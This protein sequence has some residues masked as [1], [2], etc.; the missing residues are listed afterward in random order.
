MDPVH[1]PHALKNAA[2]FRL[3]CDAMELL[4]TH[5][6]LD[7]FVVAS[8]DGAFGVLLAKLAA[9]GKRIVR[10]AVDSSLARRRFTTGEERV[11]YD[12]WCTW[13]RTS[14]PELGQALDELVSAVDEAFAQGNPTDFQAIKAALCAAAPGFDEEALG[15][16]TFRHLVYLAEQQGRIAVDADESTGVAYPVGRPRR[17]TAIRSSTRRRGP[18]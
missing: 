3:V 12:A 10:V 18:R 4:F 11:S 2:D 5:P 17:R 9:H 15:V 1:S 6:N 8:G 13:N 16:P 7:T 14:S